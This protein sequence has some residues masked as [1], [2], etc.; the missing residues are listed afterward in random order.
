MQSDGMP[1]GRTPG[2]AGPK[3]PS[4]PLSEHSERLVIPVEY[5]LEA[6]SVAPVADDSVSLSAEAIPSCP[7]IAL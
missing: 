4:L 7:Q 6:F 3:R 2:N 5:V 1:H